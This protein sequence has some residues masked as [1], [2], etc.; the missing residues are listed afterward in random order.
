MEKENIE[1]LFKKIRD[2]R[3]YQDHLCTL[4]ELPLSPTVEGEL[5]MLKTYID[6]TLV[7]WTKNPSDQIILSE[8]RK[9]A[10]IAIRGLENYGCP[11][12]D[13]IKS[14]EKGEFNQ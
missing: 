10:G 12:R 4:K 1:T 6:K 7:L 14:F 13:L 8:L 11:K 3:D 9:I 5:V 2:E